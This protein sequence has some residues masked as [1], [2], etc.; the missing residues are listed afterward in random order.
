MITGRSICR[1]SH[2]LKSLAATRTPPTRRDAPRPPTRPAQRRRRAG[3]RAPA[4]SPY[5]CPAF[6]AN[7]RATARRHRARTTRRWRIRADPFPSAT[8]TRDTRW[9]RASRTRNAAEVRTAM[10]LHDELTS[11]QRRLDDLAGP[12]PAGRARRRQPG[13]AAG[14]YRHRPPA[15]RASRCCATASAPPRRPAAAAGDGDDPGHAVRPRAVGGR[16]GRGLGVAATG[17][18]PLTAGAAPARTRLGPGVRRPRSPLRATSPP[19]R[20]RHRGAALRQP[21][22]LRPTGSPWPPTP[23]PVPDHAPRARRTYR[24]ARAAIAAR[25]LRTDRWWLAPAGHRGRAARLHRLLDLAGLR[26]RATTTRRRT[27]RRSTRPAW[28][29]NCVHHAAAARTGSSSASWWGLSPALL[30]L[31]FPLGF[32]LTCYYYRKAYYRGFWASPPACA[33]AEPHAKYTGETRFPLI[34]QNIHRYFFYVAVLVAGI[35]T[36]DTVL[37]FRDEHDAWGHMGLGTLVLPGQHRA[38]LGVHPLLPLLPA[39]RRRPAAALLQAPGALPAVGLGREAQRPPHAAGLGSLI[40]VGARRLL[41]VPG[42][43]AAPSTIR[44]SSRAGGA[45]DDEVERQAVGRRRGR[46]GRRRAAGRHRGARAGH[47][48]RRDLQVAVRQGAHGDGRGRHRRQ[49]GQRQLAA[50]TGR[51]TSATPCAAASSSTSGGWPSCTPRRRPDRVWELETWGALFD[52]THGRPDLPAQLRRP[53]VP[54]PRARRRPH[55]PGADPH[56][57]AEDRLAAAGGLRARPATTRPG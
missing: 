55:R 1:L 5:G 46:R 21:P 25:H 2:L 14:A 47:A 29:E 12:W 50:T 19:H 26:E 7:R 28:R 22:P 8:V 41:R 36:Y 9:R 24:R 32:R 54:A 31:I 3:P 13:H 38:D 11:V 40:S 18:A 44:G 15:A 30:I 57:P 35:L 39:H 45:Y 42:A 27:S 16:R 52:R 43:P 4:P 56:P 10:S 49:H 51:C 34:L 6:G 23:P 48:Y 20:T 37:A 33:V 53:R 17:H